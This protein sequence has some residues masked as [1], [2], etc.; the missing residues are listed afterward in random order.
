MN[1]LNNFLIEDKAVNMGT[2]V[3]VGPKVGIQKIDA[4]ELFF[5]VGAPRG[6]PASSSLLK[7]MNRGF[8]YRLRQ[9]RKSGA[10][11]MVKLASAT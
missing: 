10:I 6:T 11:S 1:S 5:S 8:R 3:G 4:E 2:V 9:G 7:F